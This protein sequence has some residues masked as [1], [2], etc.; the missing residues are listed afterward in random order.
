MCSANGLNLSCVYF[1]QE[2]Q[3]CSMKKSIDASLAIFCVVDGVSM[4]EKVDLFHA[5]ASYAQKSLIYLAL[6]NNQIK[7]HMYR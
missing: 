3:S 7:L 4:P 2:F 1:E 6:V 5:I